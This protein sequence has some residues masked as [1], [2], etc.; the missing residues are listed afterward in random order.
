MTKRLEA[1][2]PFWREVPFVKHTVQEQ[3]YE[4]VLRS[5][6]KGR[7][8]PSSVLQAF[9]GKPGVQGEDWSAIRHLGDNVELQPAVGIR[10]VGDKE[11]VGCVS[12]AWQADKAKPHQEVVQ[13]CELVLLDEHIDVT[14]VGEVVEL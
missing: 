14:I 8:A 2:A 4:F 6:D 5:R 13:L 9:G 11:V 7:L 10:V 3:R 12:P 1:L